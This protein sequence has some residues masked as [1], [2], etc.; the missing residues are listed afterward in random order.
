MS[1]DEREEAAA[2]VAESRREVEERMAELRGAIGRETG[3][4]PR[5][6]YAL[7]AL[8]AGAV[9]VT[10]ANRRRR[11]KKGPKVSRPGA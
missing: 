7:L 9:G 2:M 5:A 1:R 11:K 4:V 3:V 10:L 8:V 6:R